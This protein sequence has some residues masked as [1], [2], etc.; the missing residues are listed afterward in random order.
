MNFIVF[1]SGSYGGGVH[2]TTVRTQ[3]KKDRQLNHSELFNLMHFEFRH[4]QTWVICL[5]FNQKI[6]I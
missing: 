2:Y 4:R 5:N 3:F 6:P 1:T